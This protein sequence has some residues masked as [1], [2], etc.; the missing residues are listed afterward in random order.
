MTSDERPFLAKAPEPT[1]RAVAS[2]LGR[3]APLFAELERMSDGFRRDWNHAK[4][5]GWML[6]IH[7]RKKALAYVVPLAGSFRVSLTVR[8][9]ERRSLLDDPSL[10]PVHDALRD[11]KK[12]AEGYALRFDVT[13]RESFGPC[14]T[15][16]ERV[17]AAR[18][19]A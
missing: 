3:T 16:I 11:A 13:D 10:A 5:S 15:L 6:K 7:D 19:R 2:A 18:R 17:I 4:S 12:Y 9:G 8:P 14:A 1:S